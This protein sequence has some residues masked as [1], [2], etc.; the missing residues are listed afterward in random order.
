MNRILS[1]SHSESTKRAGTVGTDAN[2]ALEIWYTLKFECLCGAALPSFGV[3]ST[4][5][6]MAGLSCHNKRAVGS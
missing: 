4:D 3:S 5:E 6:D 2:D 1:I